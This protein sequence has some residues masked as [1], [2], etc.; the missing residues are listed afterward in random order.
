VH[1][2][3]K[4]NY[5][6]RQLIEITKSEYRISGQAGNEKLKSLLGSPPNRDFR[7]APTGL[8]GSSHQITVSL[9]KI[10][11]RQSVRQ[12][13]KPGPEPGRMP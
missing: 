2:V 11:P 12:R 5:Q 4:K 9:L 6:N 13:Q 8:S 7:F 10:E 3:A 1:F